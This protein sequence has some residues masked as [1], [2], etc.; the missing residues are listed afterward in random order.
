MMQKMLTLEEWA[1][2]TYETPP[3]IHTLRRW[4]RERKIY[5]PPQ[6]HGKTY[7]VVPGAQ[8]QDPTTPVR[9]LPSP[10]TAAR[11]RPRLADRI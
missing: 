5:P 6:K 8:Y 10:Q 11:G 7:R 9:S 4:A 3:N 2:A 1:A